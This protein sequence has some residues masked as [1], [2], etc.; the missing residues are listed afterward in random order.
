MRVAAAAAAAAATDAACTA[1]TAPEA[2]VET[3]STASVGAEC[4]ATALAGSLGHLRP[5]LLQLRKPEQ[6]L[7]LRA[8]ID[9][10]ARFPL[11]VQTDP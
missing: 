1:A 10:M 6:V 8:L 4:T 3:N 2:A 7:D 11:F 5:K 9:T